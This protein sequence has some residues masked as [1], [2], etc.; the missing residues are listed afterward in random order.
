MQIIYNF[1]WPLLCDERSQYVL[2]MNPTTT[3]LILCTFI[4]IIT[5]RLLSQLWLACLNV[6]I[7]FSL[8]L[9]IRSIPLSL[10]YSSFSDPATAYFSNSKSYH[11]SSAQYTL[12]SQVSTQ[13]LD[14]VKPFLSSVFCTCSCLFQS[15]T[16]LS[17]L[18]TAPFLICCISNEVIS[19]I[20]P[21]KKDT[22]LRESFFFFT[23]LIS[24]YNHFT[25]FFV[26]SLPLHCEFHKVKKYVY[27]SHYHIPNPEHHFWLLHNKNSI[28]IFWK[29]NE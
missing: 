22:I 9:K 8:L 29:I 18:Y 13:L 26:M 27:H 11:F 28:N 12:F 6:L 20:I 5:Q 17:P 19:L 23:K 15:F 24:V 3:N 14:H 25:C 4:F 10:A 7:G 2:H 1:E 21:L 16:A